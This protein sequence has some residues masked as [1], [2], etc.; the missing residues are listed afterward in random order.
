MRGKKLSENT[1]TITVSGRHNQLRIAS[2]HP[3]FNNDRII[4]KSDDE[5]ITLSVPNL[6]F[7]G[8]SCGTTVIGK[9]W[10]GLS[11]SNAPLQLG[12]FEIDEDE[13]DEDELVIYYSDQINDLTIDANTLNK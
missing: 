9:E 11:V 1:V 6:D 8:K 3:F 13:S 5:C 7:R 12:V 4:V 10:R 2:K